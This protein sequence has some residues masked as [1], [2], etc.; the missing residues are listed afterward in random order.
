M[1][2]ITFVDDEQAVL[3]GLRNLLR[4][5]RNEWD[6]FFALGGKFALEELSKTPAGTEEHLEGGLDLAFLERAGVIGD[7]PGWRAVAIAE[8]ARVAQA[9]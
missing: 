3:D 1:R 6:M 5:H 7:L 8:V 4:K 2:R 9:N